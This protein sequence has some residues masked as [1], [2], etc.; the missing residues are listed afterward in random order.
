MRLAN[1]PELTTNAWLRF[2]GIA[3]ALARTRP[4]TVLE[5]GCGQGSLGAWLARSYRY[6][7]VEQDDVSR[8]AAAARLRDVGNARIVAGLDELHGEKFDA[9]CAFEVLEHI[10]DDRKALVEWGEY[11]VPHGHML[12]S[13]PAHERSYGAWDEMVGHYRRYDRDVLQA[14]IHEAGYD[15]VDFRTHGVGIGQILDR[16]R[17]AV[18]GRLHRDKT[19]EERT[20]ASGRVLQPRSKGM[21][22]ACAALAAPFRLMQ[23]PFAHADIGVGYVVLA[24]KS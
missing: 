11:L 18:A 10:E 15:V 5:V 21:F 9:V 20:A 3:A 22:L 6:T 8:A 13:V 2:D 7:G 17:H 14:T 23:R 16:G 4:N 1:V 12:L 24:R 19:V